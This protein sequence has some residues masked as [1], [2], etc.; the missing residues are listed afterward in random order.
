VA[1]ALFQHHACAGA[2]RAGAALAWLNFE[3]DLGLPNFRRTKMSYQP[4]ALLP[5]FRARLRPASA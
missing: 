5:K 3:Q 2:G 4:A 1:Q